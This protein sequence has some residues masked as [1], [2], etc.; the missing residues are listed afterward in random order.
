MNGRLVMMLG[1]GACT[2]V[3][4][5]MASFNMHTSLQDSSSWRARMHACQEGFL[6]LLGT[7]KE[8]LGAMVAHQ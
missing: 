2:N 8:L 1:L 4:L 5:L 6:T 3:Y 7:W